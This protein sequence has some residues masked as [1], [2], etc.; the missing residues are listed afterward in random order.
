MIG[1]PKRQELVKCC[2]C[3]AL[4]SVKRCRKDTAKTCSKQ[5]MGLSR[6]GIARS[7]ETR[8]KIGISNLG[9]AG[10]R[11]PKTGETRAKMAVSKRGVLNPQYGKRGEKCHLWKG[12]LTNKNL[13]IR[14]SPECREWRKAVLARDN[15]TCQNCGTHGGWLQAHHIKRF[16]LFPELRFEVS[17]GQTL[18]EPCHRKTHR[19]SPKAPLIDLPSAPSSVPPAALSS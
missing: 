15:Y 6:Q 3:G 14:L 5:C 8:L 10:N 19:K 12:G 1:R 9:N 17:N 18:C 2:S 13:A 4:F 7:K 11:A 16:A